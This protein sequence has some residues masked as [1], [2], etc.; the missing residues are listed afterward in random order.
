MSRNLRVGTYNILPSGMCTRE[1]V[2]PDG[3]ALMKW[4][5]RRYAVVEVLNRMLSACDVVVTQENDHFFW[6]LAQL[7]KQNPHI[8]GIFGRKRVLLGDP[9]SSEHGSTNRTYMQKPHVEQYEVS[10]ENVPSE[11]IPYFQHNGSHRYISDDGIG[12][13]FNSSVVS[14]NGIHLHQQQRQLVDGLLYD[15]DKKNAFLIVEFGTVSGSYIVAGAHFP[16]GRKYSDEISRIHCLQSIWDTIT[17]LR[18]YPVMLAGDTN[19]SLRHRPIL[20]D[21][22]QEEASHDLDSFLSQLN[23][24]RSLVSLPAIVAT[25]WSETQPHLVFVDDFFVSSASSDRFWNLVPDSRDFYCFKI[26]HCFGDQKSKIGA[27]IYYSIDK[28]AL[29][30]PR[31]GTHYGVTVEVNSVAASRQ[32]AITAQEHDML[33]STFVNGTAVD[34]LRKICIGEATQDD[35]NALAAILGVDTR[36]C[37]TDIL[38]LH[39]WKDDMKQNME[40]LST[41]IK[42]FLGPLLMKLFPNMQMPSD[43]PPLHACI[44]LS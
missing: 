32:N 33:L 34:L 7:Q 37:A 5:V 21:A 36:A 3:D 10:E 2:S 29:L 8:R 13:Y 40:T 41:P 11:L 31:D 16:S 42:D 25:T 15:I 4:S 17:P 28:I 22:A 12:I 6:I 38:S 9:M 18:Q 44:C 1:F 19:T 39:A 26:R 27:I 23:S 20:I 35:Q 14:L 30:M 24:A 43:H